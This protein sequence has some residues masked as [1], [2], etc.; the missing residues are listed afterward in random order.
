VAD[1]VTRLR[2][3]SYEGCKCLHCE[4]A[5]EIDRLR[6]ERDSLS[7]QLDLMRAYL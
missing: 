1:I 3:N 7:T 6:S 4:A 2:D 5:D